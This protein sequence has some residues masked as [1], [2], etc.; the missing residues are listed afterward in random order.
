MKATAAAREN[1]MG[2]KEHA[3]YTGSPPSRRVSPVTEG[4]TME[5]LQ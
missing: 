3:R 5:G 2:G 4:F 1:V